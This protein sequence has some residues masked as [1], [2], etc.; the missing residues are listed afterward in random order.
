MA[1]NSTGER[2][3]NL[4]AHMVLSYNY[5]GYL[6]SRI[7]RKPTTFESL[8]SIM[9][10]AAEKDGTISLLYAPELV[11]RTDDENLK[12][13]ITHE[14][15]HVLNK[16]LPRFLRIAANETNP[17]IIKSKADIWNKAADCASNEQAEIKNDIIIAG[18]HWKPE[19]PERYDLPNGKLTEFYY[20]ELLKKAKKVSI[21][22]G[23]K[24]KG[25]DGKNTGSFD[26][27][28]VWFNGVSDSADISSLSRKMDNFI[29]KTIRESVKTYNKEKGNLP[30]GIR[31]LIENALALPKAPYYQIIARLI[32]ASRLSK[33]RRAFTVINR[34]RAY[35]F[36]TPDGIPLISPFPGRTRDRTF[37]IVI[38]IDTSGSMDKDQMAEALSGAKHIIEK[39]RFCH[40]TII[41]CDAQVHKEYQVKRISD[42]DP[43][44]HGRGGTT[45]GP[46]LYRAA[47][48][49]PDVCLGFTDGFTEDIN[50]LPRRKLPKK[51][52]WVIGKE[53]GKPDLLNRT[54][55][56]VRIDD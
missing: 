44:M 40:V 41:E 21:S 28:E 9:G 6:F 27:H 38:L 52:I 37:K 3:K 13:V 47:E 15:M 51:I 45:L 25:K 4:I 26:N 8:G 14:G 23:G 50:A 43:E 11:D 10:V 49:F 17:L 54:G 24:C 35:L 56:V 39:D 53:R 32:R 16:H 7:S 18:E 46:G 30:A 29:Q 1:D 36:D 48:L 19:L 31:Q 20:L 33:F 22:F 5:W 34:K 42:I 2:L 55:F 12:T